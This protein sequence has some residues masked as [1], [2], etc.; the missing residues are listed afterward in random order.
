MRIGGDFF[1]FVLE[2]SYDK[3]AFGSFYPLGHAHVHYML[4]IVNAKC[5]K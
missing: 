1:F 3:D 4:S 5:I 2:I